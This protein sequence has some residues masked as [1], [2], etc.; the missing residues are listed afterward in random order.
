M[1]T[2]TQRTDALEAEVAQMRAELLAVRCI[3]EIAFQAGLEAGR[4]AEAKYRAAAEASRP[5]QR[6]LQVVRSAP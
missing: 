4:P 5:R 3:D 6:H 2:N 1:A